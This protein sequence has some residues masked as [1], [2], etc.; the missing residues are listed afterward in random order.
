SAHAHITDERRA[1]GK[2]LLVGSWHVRMRSKNRTDA[3]LQMM[4][5]EIFLSRRL[6]M[7]IA[8]NDR[9]LAVEVLQHTIRR[10]EG[11]IDRPHVIPAEHAERRHKRSIARR[12]HR[13]FAARGIQ[14]KVGRLA[15]AFLFLQRLDDLGLLVDVVAERDEIDTRMANAAI[16]LAR[17]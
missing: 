14:R 8:D 7:N 2:N 17:D 5:D 1:A 9:R 13:E 10:P 6:G 12:R 16:E 15:D 4:S 3:A 11:T